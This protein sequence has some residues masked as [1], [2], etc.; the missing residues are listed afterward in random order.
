M[1]KVRV[2]RCLPNQL[3][4]LEHDPY[5]WIDEPVLNLAVC[6]ALPARIF[7]WEQAPADR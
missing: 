6:T 2:W 3:S 5:L 7:A 1:T 4:E